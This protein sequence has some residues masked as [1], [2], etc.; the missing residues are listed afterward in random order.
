MV[1]NLPEASKFQNED[2]EWGSLQAAVY[3]VPPVA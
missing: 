3:G 1:M 2:C